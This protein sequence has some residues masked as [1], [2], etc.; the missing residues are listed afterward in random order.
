MLNVL[1]ES[2]VGVGRQEQQVSVERSFVAREC[3]SSRS[4]ANTTRAS[5]V[6]SVNDGQH[7]LLAAPAEQQRPTRRLSAPVDTGS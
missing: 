2:I 7:E 6:F 5:V 4:L 1:A 3:I